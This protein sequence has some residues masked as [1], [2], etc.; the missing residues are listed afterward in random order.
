MENIWRQKND[1]R[2]V[3]NLRCQLAKGVLVRNRAEN[4][5]VSVGRLDRFQIT[6]PELRAVCEGYLRS[7]PAR[8]VGRDSVVGFRYLEQKGRLVLQVN[9]DRQRFHI[10][11]RRTSERNRFLSL[12]D[13]E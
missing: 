3:G 7:S 10:P 6:Q 12:R 1:V 2:T 11:P 13:T 9:V 5:G 4:A 8:L